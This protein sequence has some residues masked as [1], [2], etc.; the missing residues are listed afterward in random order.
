MFNSFALQINVHFFLPVEMLFSKPEG[1]LDDFLR[2]TAHEIFPWLLEI[3][4]KLALGVWHYAE[5]AGLGF[6][7]WFFVRNHWIFV[8]SNESKSQP[9][10]FFNE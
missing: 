5:A 10:L 6:T 4:L 1:I 9:S 7:L 8:K 2:E 3:L